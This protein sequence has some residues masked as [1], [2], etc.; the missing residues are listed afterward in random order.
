MSFLFRVTEL[1][2]FCSCFFAVSFLVTLNFCV[3]RVKVQHFGSIYLVTLQAD[4]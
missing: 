4:F 1:C 3:K 2:L